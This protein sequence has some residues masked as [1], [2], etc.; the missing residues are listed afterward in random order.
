MAELDDLV[1]ARANIAARLREITATPKPSYSID[2]QTFSW[3][4]YFEALSRQ[5]RSLGELAGAQDEY[6]E[7]TQ[8]FT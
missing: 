2:G 3:T 7:Q 5:Y 6:F 8:L 4:E 1:A